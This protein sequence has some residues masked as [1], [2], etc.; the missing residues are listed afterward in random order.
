MALESASDRL[1]KL[2]NRPA[3]DTNNVMVASELLHRNG[4]KFMIQNILALPSSTIEEDMET[5]E[6]NIRCKPD[7]GWASI[8]SPYPGTVLGDACLVKGW[9]KGDYSNI[10]DCFFDRSVLEFTGEQKEQTY[11]LQKVFALC[12]ESGYMLVIRELTIAEM[13]KLI[14]NAMRK[15]GDGRLYKG[16]L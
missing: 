7:Y 10:T 13:P 12:V 16:I 11:V 4:I 14:H 6:F 2:M 8:F 15:I 1:R 3:L 5:L 9:Y